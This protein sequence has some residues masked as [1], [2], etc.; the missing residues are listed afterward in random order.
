MI[1]PIQAKKSNTHSILIKIPKV[2]LFVRI[3]PYLKY[4]DVI[5]LSTTCVGLRKVIF[6]PIGWKLLSRVLTPYPLIIKEIFVS[7]G[8]Q[9][10]RFSGLD[11]D[12][13]P[14]H[15]ID[16]E[17]LL[18]KARAECKKN[19][20]QIYDKFKHKQEEHEELM[21]QLRSETMLLKKSKMEK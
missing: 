10:G 1:N 14:V 7:E 4:D 8:I 11:M 15:Q 17:K 21:H 3:V 16:D 19:L 13:F 5:E 2:I 9:T 20:M 12:N 6:S 18:K